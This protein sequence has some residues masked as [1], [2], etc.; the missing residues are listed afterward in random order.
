[1]LKSISLLVAILFAT[2]MINSVAALGAPGVNTEPDLVGTEIASITHDEV[3]EENQPWH[4][5]VEVD[6][7]AIANG[8]TV[9]A[10]TVQIC[11]NQGI[12]LSPT[13]MELS[14]QGNNWSGQTIP[15]WA[16]CTFSEFECLSTYV[17]WKVTLNNSD[18]NISTIP[19]TGFYTTWSTCWAYLT[20]KGG[21]GCPKATVVE[22]DDGFL[23]GFGITLTITSLF[24][25]GIALRVRTHKGP[26]M[27]H[28]DFDDGSTCFSES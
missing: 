8:T 12:C 21:N 4:F 18:G 13:P 2:L 9:E 27:Q 20:E 11:V 24:A 5:S 15:H 14:R 6:G 19:E 16:E 26:I 28:S 17:N 3:A 1:V 25:A 7:D 23:P 10:V 22:A